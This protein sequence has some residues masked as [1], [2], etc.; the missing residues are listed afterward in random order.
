VSAELFT[1]RLIHTGGSLV[2]RWHAM[3][4]ADQTLSMFIS[5]MHDGLTAIAVCRSTPY[6]A[7]L[8]ALCIR[9]WQVAIWHVAPREPESC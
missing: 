9:A 2:N 7:A 4:C 8:R 3:L 6:H 5:G 1:G